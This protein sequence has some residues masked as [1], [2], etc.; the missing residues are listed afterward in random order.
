MPVNSS[1][2]MLNMVPQ[3]SKWS[4]FWQRY[5][6]LKKFSKR[7]KLFLKKGSGDHGIPNMMLYL[8]RSPN[9]HKK[10]N[11]NIHHTPILDKD[12]AYV[13]WVQPPPVPAWK[14][15]QCTHSESAVSFIGMIWIINFPRFKYCEKCN[16]F[17]IFEHIFRLVT[18]YTVL[19]RH[20]FCLFLLREKLT[21]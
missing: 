16:N 18:L 15:S 6:N 10:L 17:L 11:L 9:P 4:N 7:E 14:C 2:K 1:L 8:V 12:I 21:E 19:L 3:L 5:C 20:R 13:S